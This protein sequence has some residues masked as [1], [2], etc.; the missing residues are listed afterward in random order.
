MI[1][2]RYYRGVTLQ[3]QGKHAEAVGHLRGVADDDLGNLTE[4]QRQVMRWKT[5]SA[6]VR[7]YLA[8]GDNDAALEVVARSRE[9]DPDAEMPAVVPDA[10][11]PEGPP[12]GDE[13]TR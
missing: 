10:G 1:S 12:A 9:R 3:V 7:S 6:L 5:G 2:Y 13:K 4:T 11:G 8:L